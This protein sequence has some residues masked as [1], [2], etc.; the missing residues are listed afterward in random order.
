M[1]EQQ[2]FCQQSSALTE[3]RFHGNVPR[4]TET[5]D[6]QRAH[7]QS[8]GAPI[9]QCRVGRTRQHMLEKTT[10]TVVA[11]VSPWEQMCR[12][13]LGGGDETSA[14][15]QGEIFAQVADN[16][17][18]FIA[19]LIDEYRRIAHDISTRH[20]HDVHCS[21]QRLASLQGK[22]H[23]AHFTIPLAEVRAEILLEGEIFESHTKSVCQGNL[24]GKSLCRSQ[25]TFAHHD[26]FTWAMLDPPRQRPSV[27]VEANLWIDA[28]RVNGAT[29]CHRGGQEQNDRRSHSPIIFLDACL[30]IVFY[31]SPSFIDVMAGT[32]RRARYDSAAQESIMSTALVFPGQGAQYVGMAMPLA[33]Q[34]PAAQALLAQAD[35][36]LGFSLSQVIAEG[37]E[38]ELTRTDISQPAILVA[39]LMALE[40]LKSKHAVSD[41]SAVAGLSLGE[42]TAL[43]VAGS[44]T[45]PDAVKLVRLRG[46]AMQAAAEAVPSGMVALIGPDEATAQKLCDAAAQGDVLQVANLNATGQVVISGTKTA[47]ERAIALAKDFGIRRA[48]ALP[49]AGAFHSALMAPAAER[50]KAGLAATPIADPKIPVYT[51]V[52]AGPVTKASE[53]PDLLVRQLTN[54]VRWAQSV[55]NMQA[56]GI[57]EFW[58][59]GPNKHLSGMIARTVQNVV[60][61]NL[62]KPED[63]A[64]F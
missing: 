33:A 4:A 38:A 28:R 2:T 21:C 29:G 43:V 27:I 32:A 50:L 9:C 61:K 39:S 15:R 5:N 47:C 59:I 55:Q 37:P 20:L 52:H 22:L 10:A 14:V 13:E 12:Q 18:R 3:A 64:Q 17:R 42:Y 41:I 44:L 34:F 46:E 31:H 25:G 62:D 23:D 53:I 16:I 63:M 1:S 49:V 6:V 30:A 57:S 60:C 24:F 26:V 58:E 7:R 19:H 54:P 40:A 8:P 45:F 11:Q 36:V 35:A 51:N 48:V 56:A